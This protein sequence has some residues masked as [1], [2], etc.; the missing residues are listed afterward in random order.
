MAQGQWVAL[1]ATFLFAT[2]G[3]NFRFGGLRRL[4][5]L[6]FD[7]TWPRIYRNGVFVAIPAAA[8]AGSVLLLSLTGPP[9]DE[10]VESPLV[11][12]VL[13]TLMSISLAM[14]LVTFFR[15]VKF[16]KPK[17]IRE[18]DREIAADP[19]GWKRRTEILRELRRR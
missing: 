13:F 1:V 18:A 15:P 5:W 16:L 3:I 7:T 9:V 14:M 10:R 2:L 19:S 11:E 17:W 6:Y 8:T 12:L 4:A